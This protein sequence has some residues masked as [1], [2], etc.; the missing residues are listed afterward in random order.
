MGRDLVRYVCL[1][2]WG[3]RCFMC[4]NGDFLVFSRCRCVMW[5]REPM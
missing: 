4:N 5:L 3:R 2:V 1:G